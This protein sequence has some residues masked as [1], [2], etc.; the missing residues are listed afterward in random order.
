MNITRISATF[1]RGFLVAVG[2]GASVAVAGPDTAG[3][4]PVDSSASSDGAD[5]AATQEPAS[6]PVRSGRSAP[7]A[8]INT[9]RAPGIA[10]GAGPVGVRPD[11]ERSEA[12]SGPALSAVPV[13]KPKGVVG[14]PAATVLQS[15]QLLAAE[16][17]GLPES[18]VVVTHARVPA[19]SV[20]APPAVGL[21]APA[22]VVSA[23]ESARPVVAA[24]VMTP[25]RPAAGAIAASVLAPL[26]GSGSGLPVQSPASWV[27]VAAARREVGD[28]QAAG[29]APAAAVP[30]PAAAIVASAV[31]ANVGTFAAPSFADIVGYTFVHRAPTADPA[32]APGQ[33]PAG[34]V[35]GNL[36]ARSDT[37]AP[38]T[39]TLAGGPA[40]G[41]VDLGSDGSYVYTPNAD[42]AQIGGGDSFSVRIDDGSAYRLSGL[43]GALQGFFSSLAQLVGLREPDTITATV[44]VTVV[45]VGG[46]TVNS[47]PVLGIPTVG[48][49]NVTTGVVAGS[50]SAV[51]AD[52]DSLSF[53]GSG[54]TGRGS[55]VVTAGGAFS[56]TP[57]QAARRAATG[58]TTD[59]FT[60]TVDDG[61]DTDVV[62]VTVAVDPGTP[63]AGTATVG[64]PDPST[65]VVS[66][67]A[68][69]TDTA[70]RALSYSTP[71]SSA[72]GGS[73]V[74][75][76]ATGVFTFI[77]TAA[78]RLAD[79]GTDTFTVTASN[80]V[81]S[82]STTVTVPVGSASGPVAEAGTFPVALVN[83]TGGVWPDDQIHVTILGQASP[84]VWSWVDATGAVRPLDHTAADVPGHLTK[85]GVNY[86]DMSFTLA[87]AAGLTV[88]TE[89][90]SARVYISVGQPVYIGVSADDRGWASPDPA[91]PSDPNY[92]TVYDWYEMSY[93]YGR[94]PFGGNTTQV[95]QFGLPLTITLEQAA[96][97]FAETRGL[98]LT[99]DQVFT[100][101]A[102]SVP[103][104]FQSLVVTD[105][106]GNPL[107][108]LA[109]RSR[110]S[111]A[112]STWFNAPVN[113][114][115]ATYSNDTFSYA[116]PG[117]TVTGHIDANSRFA[118][119]VATSGGTASYAMAKPTTS[120]IFANN[121]PFVGT[122]AQGAFLAELAAAFNR[123]VAD[124]PEQWDNVAAY[125]PAG[126]QWNAYA[127]FFHEI[128]VGNF[129]YGFPY[130]DVNSQSS[131][132]ILG[133]AQPPTRL[134]IAV[135]AGA[136]TGVVVPPSTPSL[137]VIE[138]GGSV[139]LLSDPV[140]GLAY[141]QSADSPALAVTRSDSYWTGP[142]PLT[143]SGATLFA[144]ERDSAGR[145][146][147]LD[148]SGYGQYG[149]ILDESGRFT[150]EE[151]YDT[152][153]LPGAE[154]LFGVDVNGDGI[155]GAAPAA[156]TTPMVPTAGVDPTMWTLTWSDEFNVAGAQPDQTQWGYDLGGGG[157]GNAELQ[158]Y[159]SR[160]EN[161]VTDADGRL[162]ITAIKENL[163][164][165]SCWYG[166][167]QYTSG[168]I[169]TKN[170]FTQ[171]YGRFE[172]SIK[173]PAG[174][175]MWPA[176]W[177]QGDAAG[178]AGTAWPN[179]GELD[180]ME[181]I[182]REPSTVHG[183]LHGP[184]YSGGNAITGSY[185]LP[186]GQRFSD[187]FHVF[188]VEWEPDEIRWYVDGIP[189]QTRTRAD[190]P[191]GAP[192]VFDH[193]FYLILNSAV[194]GQWPGSPD[195]TTQF[196]Q[197]MLIDYVRVYV[198]TLAS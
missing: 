108:I 185:T 25:A 107:R 28:D 20:G 194:G 123:G 19:A 104:E 57:T 151:K 41:N 29:P 38:M 187:D 127:K 170:T 144:A 174:Q 130:D 26:L 181:N 143:R 42:L 60:V 134:T 31:T 96:T 140:T 113:D 105:T 101:F 184:G 13:S 122:G 47:A 8:R 34:V 62:T 61:T 110:Q 149:W 45:G 84:G 52:G 124:N 1:G 141:V 193:P 147:V 9:R 51:D 37:G 117:Y 11:S 146:R 183:S 178:S 119:T 82:V 85:D 30:G 72:G 93:A 153:T 198:P 128:G 196:P 40:S 55:V 114:F 159:T 59:T 33:S 54:V 132:Q 126:Q 14:I 98:T 23:M 22:A 24:P 135:L 166:A 106:A 90:L 138:A 148:S 66:G 158:Y 136:P 145:L 6:A 21:T 133:N 150:G 65:G 80:G 102:Q 175:G 188:A 152:A 177:M 190:L 49:P 92:S 167:C 58:A 154:A 118:Y 112:L 94:T 3:A 197:Q 46:P 89:L 137:Q 77:P 191:A 116:G 189:Y 75:D 44:T 5:S 176:F 63:V 12:R 2:L 115:W 7:I 73:L 186:A 157:F 43:G 87:E 17:V 160:P 27:M 156:P 97:G 180:I 39:Y 68:V 81:R 162:A 129:A 125:Y 69:F 78:Q 76:G 111:P 103:P 18:A 35:T 139:S 155:I 161:V 168:R 100:R 91:N 142:V 164:G 50:V 67:S 32:Q 171:E 79:V 165:S 53:S 10:S 163:P 99:R 36:N 48:V 64:G 74:I 109:P 172:A 56:Y 192:W 16:P 4:A 86:P 88:P 83:D 71:A 70:G 182:G 15:G 169:L 173:L 195:G 121:G 179:R 120:E 95:D 131:V